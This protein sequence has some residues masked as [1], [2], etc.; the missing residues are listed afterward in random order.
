[1][2]PKRVCS[3]KRFL[4]GVYRPKLLFLWCFKRPINKE[5]ERDGS[6]MKEKVC[7]ESSNCVVIERQ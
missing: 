3:L 6:R 5:D 7:R 2:V 4:S 1:M